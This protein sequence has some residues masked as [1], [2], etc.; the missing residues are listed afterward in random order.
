MQPD[1]GPLGGQAGMHCETGV[2]RL[3]WMRQRREGSSVNSCRCAALPACMRM[4]LQLSL[5]ATRVEAGCICCLEISAQ[6]IF[7]MALTSACAHGNLALQKEANA[8]TAHVQEDH[9]ERIVLT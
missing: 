1:G 8:P 3:G 6:T 9:K 2:A 5:A 7:A 4:P